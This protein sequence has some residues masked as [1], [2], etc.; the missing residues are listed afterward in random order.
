MF[1]SKIVVVILGALIIGAVGSA[2]GVLSVA[3]P[4]AA[5]VGST[6]SSTATGTSGSASAT[7]TGA[8]TAT[9][10]PTLASSPNPTPTRVLPTATPIPQ[11]GQTLDLHGS[12][13]SINTAN[14][15]FMLR[16]SG[17]SYTV[18]VNGSTQWPGTAKS[19]SG[20]PSPPLAQGMQAEVVGVYQ[21]GGN[22][23]ASKVDAQPDN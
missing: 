21:G 2:V 17:S 15:T 16:V 10:T 4:G 9:D 14:S 8:A 1:R 12:V 18:T 7:P 13:G 19:I 3:R 22:I 11:V 23:Q 5:A 6:A 20:T